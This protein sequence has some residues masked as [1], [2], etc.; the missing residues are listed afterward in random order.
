MLCGTGFS[1][2][3]S[4]S[5]G[6]AIANKLLSLENILIAFQKQ[7]CE[8][9]YS[10]GFPFSAYLCWGL[11]VDTG[12]HRTDS[13]MPSLKRQRISTC[14]VSPLCLLV[15]LWWQE[16][17]QWARSRWKAARGIQISTC[18][19]RGILI[20]IGERVCFLARRSCQ[21]AW[22]VCMWA[23]KIGSMFLLGLLQPETD[24]FV[25]RR[26]A[27]PQKILPHPRFQ[28]GDPFW[29]WGPPCCGQ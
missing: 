2:T 29:R 28:F 11:L 15:R 18:W 8:L 27:Y 25:P 13:N 23:M 24:L 19:E 14:A 12:S 7:K 1:C 9:D 4:S 26:P 16:M 22:M 20:C 17:A 21:F 5:W 3:S 6:R 10:I